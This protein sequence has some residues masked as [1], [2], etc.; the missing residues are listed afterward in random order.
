ML[1]KIALTFV[2][3]GGVLAYAPSLDHDIVIRG[4]TL[5]DGTGSPGIVAV[6]SEGDYTGELPG[7][8]LHRP[9]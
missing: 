2:T 3:L 4:G 9:A 7:R 1:K 5:F 6:V 8:A